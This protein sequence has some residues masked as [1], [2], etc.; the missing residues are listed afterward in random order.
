MSD[1]FSA[2]GKIWRL[3]AAVEPPADFITAVEQSPL[4][5]KILLNRGIDTVLQA[6]AFLSPDHYVPTGPF[7]LPDM[8]KTLAELIGPHQW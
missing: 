4:L 6:N 5:A 8:D 1:S 3:P 2:R 7:E